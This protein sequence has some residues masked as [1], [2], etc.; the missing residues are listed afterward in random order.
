LR[1][2]FGAPPLL[3]TGGTGRPIF[4][5]RLFPCG[6]RPEVVFTISAFFAIPLPLHVSER[7]PSLLLQ[8]WVE[9][10]M[11]ANGFKA[12]YLYAACSASQPL[13]A[14]RIGFGT[15]FSPFE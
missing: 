11:R 5:K 13:Q 3:L 2:P 14:S 9:M 7:H 4:A 8:L 10:V 6:F 15:G 12:A 1:L